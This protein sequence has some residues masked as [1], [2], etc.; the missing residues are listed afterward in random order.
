MAKKEQIKK[1]ILE[2]FRL[3]GEQVFKKDLLEF[4]SARADCTQKE[5]GE[6]LAE[7]KE[8]GKIYSVKGMPGF[9]GLFV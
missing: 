2:F 9:V 4:V 7:M 3:E 8:E 6:V 5:A 1:N